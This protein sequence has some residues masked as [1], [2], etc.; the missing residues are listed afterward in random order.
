M[1]QLD[2]NSILAY[3]LL[4]ITVVSALVTLYKSIFP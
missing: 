4:I 1:K 3:G 2:T